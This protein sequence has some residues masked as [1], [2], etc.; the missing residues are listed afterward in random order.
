MPSTTNGKVALR[1]VAGAQA[2][3]L[4]T[5]PRRRSNKEVRVREYLTEDECRT[6]IATAKKRGGAARRPSNP[7]V[8]APWVARLRTRGAKLGSCRMENSA[9]HGASRQGLG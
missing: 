6:L 9:P 2:K 7:H 8:L 1:V 4:A 3:R 5:P